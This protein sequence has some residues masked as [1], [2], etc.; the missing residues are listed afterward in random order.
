MS[1]LKKIGGCFYEDDDGTKYFCVVDFI[2]TSPW[3]DTPAMRKIVIE[4]VRE[5]DPSI[6]IL[7]EEFTDNTFIFFRPSDTS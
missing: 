4:E 1:P 6:R 2:W 7:E 5:M 3:S